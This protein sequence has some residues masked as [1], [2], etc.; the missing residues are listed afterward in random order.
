MHGSRRHALYL[1]LALLSVPAAAADAPDKP[2]TDDS[3]SA[4][5]VALTPAGDLNLRKERIPALLVAAQDRPYG[6]DG[7]AECPAL[8]GAIAEFDAVLGPDLDQPQESKGKLTAGRVAQAAV[9]AFIPFRGLIREVSGAN[10][11]DRKLQ[12]A[13]DAGLARRGFLKGYAQARGCDAPATIAASTAPT[14]VSRPVV[15]S[16]K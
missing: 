11:H 16:T 12:A 9:T 5:D 3:V 4:K 14:F 2:I 7:L 6:L 13:I 1:V 8:I 10:G 15:Q